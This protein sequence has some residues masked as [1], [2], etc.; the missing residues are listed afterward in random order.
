[1]YLPHHNVEATQVLN[2][3]PC[4]IVEELLVN[5]N[6]FITRSGIKRATMGILD[7]DKRTFAKPNE[8]HNE[9]SKGEYI[10]G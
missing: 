3:I 9:E 2:G 8:L 7:K 10:Q 4:I 1:M 5:P 6:N